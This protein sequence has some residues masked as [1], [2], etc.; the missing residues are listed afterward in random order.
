MIH[1]LLRVGEAI[2]SLT[3]GKSELRRAGC[4]ITSGEGDLRD[5]ATEMKTAGNGKGG[6]VR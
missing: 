3:R 1:L 6:T 2:A 4:R 5:S